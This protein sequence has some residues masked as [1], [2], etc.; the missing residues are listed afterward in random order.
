MQAPTTPSGSPAQQ[1]DERTCPNC[2]APNG[3][4]AAFCWQCY[5]PFGAYRAPGVA[6]SPPDRGPWT[7]DMPAAPPA[8]TR[9]P[10]PFDTPARRPN[11]VGRIVRVVL[12]TL[13]AIGIVTWWVS[14]DGSVALPETFGGLG[15]MENAQTELIVDTFHRKLD[16]MGIEGDIA[17]YGAGLPTSA[18]VWIRDAAAP[19][20]DAAF[21]QFATGFDSGI[22]GGASLDGSRKTVETLDGVTY[23]CAPLVSDVSGTIC[24]WQD[25]DV[26]W[27]LID[28]SGASFEAGKG[29]A[30]GAHDAASAA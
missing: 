21:D 3:L 22:G 27:L 7:P 29:L 24:M 28:F 9:T 6:G 26:F 4:T 11:G 18:L 23:V 15:K 19:T 20:T 12:V 2:G 16:T 10:S 14:R 8:W 17:M 25:Q 5:Q 13:A 30:Q 1:P